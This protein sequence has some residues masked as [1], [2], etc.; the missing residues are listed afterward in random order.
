MKWKN[1]NKSLDCLSFKVIRDRSKKTT[2]IDIDHI[3]LSVVKSPEGFI[4]LLNTE[5]VIYL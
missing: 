2:K 4:N 3:E 1:Y 5:K